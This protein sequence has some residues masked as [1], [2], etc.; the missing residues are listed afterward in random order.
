MEHPTQGLTPGSVTL[1][2]DTSL[3]ACI[4]Q[5]AVSR[6]IDFFR[7]VFYLPLLDDSLCENLAERSHSPL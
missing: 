4:L 3:L 2:R 6:R 1:G 5:F 7:M